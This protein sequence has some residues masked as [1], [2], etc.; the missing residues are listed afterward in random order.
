MFNKI[1]IESTDIDIESYI[2]K[3][4]IYDFFSKYINPK[5]SYDKITNT[6]FDFNYENDVLNIM[7]TYNS[8]S[9]FIN[10]N[11]KGSITAVI[12]DLYTKED[13]LITVHY[14]MV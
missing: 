5:Y 6:M 9:T 13:Y 1:S 14:Y 3:K 7:H 8:E 11:D 10:R 2:N 4:R 12:T